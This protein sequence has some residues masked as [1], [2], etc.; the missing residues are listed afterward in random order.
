MS[1]AKYRL[2]SRPQC[3]TRPRN[4]WW[5]SFRLLF[6]SWLCCTGVYFFYNKAS[7]KELLSLIR[8]KAASLF[9]ATFHSLFKQAESVTPYSGK[10]HFLRS[11][12]ICCVLSI[13]IILTNEW[14]CLDFTK[15]FLEINGSG[16]VFCKKS[17][18]I[19]VV[20]LD[21]T[22]DKSLP[23]PVMTKFN[24]AKWDHLA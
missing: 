17:A 2:F 16:Y 13:Y 15:E 20:A 7:L 1:S 11:Q 21:L 18:L 23:E 4:Y 19:Q 24:N 5:L 12:C 3:I 22:G 14:K 6:G 9:Q 10:D 8:F